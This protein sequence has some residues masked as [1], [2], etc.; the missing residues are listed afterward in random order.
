MRFGAVLRLGEWR[1][2]KLCGPPGAMADAIRGFAALGVEEIIL[3]FCIVPFQVAD[4]SAPD[5]FATQ[6][7]QKSR[8][9]P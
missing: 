2:D 3:S 5:L 8:T 6:M 4:P 1:R 9:S 7:F